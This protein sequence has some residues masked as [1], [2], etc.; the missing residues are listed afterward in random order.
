L[1]NLKSYG[2]TPRLTL[3]F[4]M[5]TKKLTWIRAATL[6]ATLKTII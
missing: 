3:F 6:L 2:A 1:G 4:Q 5:I